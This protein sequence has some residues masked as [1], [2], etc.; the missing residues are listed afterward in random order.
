MGAKD[1]WVT[2]NSDGTIDLYEE[3]DGWSFVSGGPQRTSQKVTLE[4]LKTRHPRL[5]SD[6]VDQLGKLLLS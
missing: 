1:R 4:H 3:N 5:Y 2:V 6:A